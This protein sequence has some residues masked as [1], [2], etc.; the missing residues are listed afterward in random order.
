MYVKYFMDSNML[1][2]LKILLY[3]YYT[4][5]NQ[6]LKVV[7]F[8]HGQQ[9]RVVLGLRSALNNHHISARVVRCFGE[10]L[11][12]QRLGDVVGARAG[13][14]VALPASAASARAG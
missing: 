5:Y 1:L 7:C 10:D 2:V 11:E 4:L 8:G 9:D 13:N 12:K 14:E 3:L 6:A